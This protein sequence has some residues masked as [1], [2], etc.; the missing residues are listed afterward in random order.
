MDVFDLFAKISLDSSEY[1]KGLNDAKSKGDSA[2]SAIGGAFSKIGSVLGGIGKTVAVGV[3]AA[4]AGVIALSKESL[5]AYGNYEQLVGGV[6][7]LYGNMGQSLDE[8]VKN[9]TDQ[10]MAAEEAE[11]KWHYLEKAQTDVLENAKN[12]YKTSGLSANEYME[13]ATSFSAALISSLEGD[14]VKAAEQTEVAMRA[15]S[16]NANTFGTSMDSIQNAFMGFSKQNYT[17]LDNLKLGYG[18]TKKEME[19]LIEDANKYAEANGKAADLSIDSFSDIVTAIQYIQEEQNIAGTTAREAAGTIQGSMAMT[20]SAWQNLVAGFSNPD[21]D[22]GQLITNVVDSATIAFGNLMPAIERGL[23]G[24]ASFVDK[25]APILSE[26]LPKAFDTVLPVAIKALTS[27]AESLSNS[28][29][30]IINVLVAQIPPLLTE[31][32]PAAM[33]II[34][35]LGQGFMEA[36]PVLLEAAIT[37]IGMFVTMMIENLPT[38]VSSITELITGLAQMISENAPSIVEGAIAL[39]T[40]L[41]TSLLEN[42]PTIL[43]AVLD[44]VLSIAKALIDNAPQLLLSLAQILL[45]LGKAMADWNLE[46]L[47]KVGQFFIDILKKFNDWDKDVKTAVGNFFKDIF[48]KLKTWFEQDVVPKVSSFFSDILTKLGTWLTGDDSLTKKITKFFDDI[49]ESLKTWIDEKV[50]KKVTGFFGDIVTKLAEWLT[51]T[52]SLTKKVTTFFDDIYNKLKTWFDEQI[53]KKISG[54]FTQLITDVKTW[55]TGEGGVTKKVEDFIKGILEKLTTFV[56]DLG[57]KASDAA[58]EFSEKLINGVK[59]LPSK[60]FEVGSNIVSG[61][62]EGIKSG[63]DWLTD[64]VSDLANSLFDAAKSALGI[65]S[66]SKKFMWIG[67]MT[68]KGLTAGLEKYSGLVDK[69]MEDITTVPDVNMGDIYGNGGGTTNTANNNVVINVYGAVGQDV[70]E[71]AEIISRKIDGATG[72]RMVA[73]GVA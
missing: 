27:L 9:A 65:S 34:E 52:D 22:L 37:V 4:S 56:T 36:A 14:T 16:D 51:G 71:L 45:Q 46:I 63:W 62:W 67:E 35:Q 48:D 38:I 70:N 17:M 68:D 44:I 7:K 19:R 6:N 49:F 50:V 32:M 55:L 25:I 8:Y 60:F 20:K 54:F 21:A 1:D 73:M 29:V 64:A 69:A 53:V 3:G 15:M 59:D 39:I 57:K 18:G 72:R 11:S 31:L 24:I 2:S 28:L 23:E 66:P 30:D 41:A 12:A 42:L 58:K 61:I 26:N 40:T 33:Q 47:K 13:T 43:S 5:D 10:G